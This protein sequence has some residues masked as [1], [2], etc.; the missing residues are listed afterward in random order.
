[1]NIVLAVPSTPK[2]IKSDVINNTALSLSWTT[3]DNPNGKILEYQII[4]NGYKPIV[5]RQDASA[6]NIIDGPKVINVPAKV[7]ENPVY[8]VVISDLVAGL[9]YEIKV[10]SK[11]IIIIRV[12]NFEIS[13]VA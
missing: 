5:K 2:Q 6:K 12:L 4:Y 8:T 10:I 7:G 13:I 11:S 9:T 1:M 3:P